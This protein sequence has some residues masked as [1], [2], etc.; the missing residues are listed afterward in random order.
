[1]VVIGDGR[2]FPAALIVPDWQ[3]L[4]GYAQYKGYDLHTRAEFCRDPRII[5]LFERQIAAR[6]REL[7][8]FEKVKRIALLEKEFT[9][10]GGEL[11]PT[12]KVK[13]RVIDQEYREV[14]DG[15][16]ESEARP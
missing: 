5:D 6:T 14:I 12:L 4:E 13:R 1:V 8:Q 9:L 2:K 7:A 16:Y 10:E 11:T 15:I 3:Q